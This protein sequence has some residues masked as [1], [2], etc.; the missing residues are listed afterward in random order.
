MFGVFALIVAALNIYLAR[1]IFL[2]SR[3]I[4][5]PATKEEDR[6]VLTKKRRRLTTISRASVVLVVATYLISIFF[7]WS[8]S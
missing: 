7:G 5:D 3:L 1:D 2:L 8:K 4:L 6:V